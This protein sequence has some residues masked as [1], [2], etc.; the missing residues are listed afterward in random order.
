[1]ARQLG[2]LACERLA[3]LVCLPYLHARLDEAASCEGVAHCVSKIDEAERGRGEQERQ[4][5]T[6]VSMRKT[7]STPL[8]MRTLRSSRCAYTQFSLPRLHIRGQ[9][10]F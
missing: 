1:M 7:P 2:Y 10:T 3:L 6:A 5:R 9:C 4:V 8:P